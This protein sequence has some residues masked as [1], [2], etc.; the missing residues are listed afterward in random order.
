MYDMDPQ[1]Y[2][3]KM[4]DGQRYL[5]PAGKE[6]EYHVAFIVDADKMNNMVLFFNPTGRIGTSDSDK[7]KQ[8]IIKLY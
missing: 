8:A 7:G 1:T 3:R 2:S 6:I 5:I 4:Y